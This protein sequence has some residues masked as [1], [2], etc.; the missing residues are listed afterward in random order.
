MMISKNWVIGKNNLISKLYLILTCESEKLQ[1]IGL[2]IK[3]NPIRITG[4]NI[5]IKFWNSSHTRNKF[6]PSKER[7]ETQFLNIFFI[8]QQIWVRM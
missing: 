7:L 2:Q 8:S 6:L 3:K 1:I 5:S 4:V